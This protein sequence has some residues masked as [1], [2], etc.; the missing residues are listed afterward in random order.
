M[1]AV[2]SPDNNIDAE[3]ADGV[4][5]ADLAISSIEKAQDAS[6]PPSVD[7]EEKTEDPSNGNVTSD[8]TSNG[9]A[10]QW[11]PLATVDSALLS[12]LLDPRERRALLR[13]ERVLAEFTDS[14]LNSIEVGGAFNTIVLGENE[15]VDRGYKLE[16]CM[17]PQNVQEF[18]FQ[19]S[20]GLRQTS[21]QRL[22]LH[23]LADRFGIVREVIPQNEN[24]VTSL[25]LIRLI[26]TEESCVPERMVAEV[27]PSVLVGWRNPLARDSR[28]NNN[29]GYNN[30]GGCGN[31]NA[32]G[33]TA[34]WSPNGEQDNMH[35]L[36][37]HMANSSLNN[38][39]A[40]Q[41]T[42]KMV[43]MKRSST[44]GSNNDGGKGKKEGKSRNRKKLVDKEKAYEEA[45]ARI[46]GV[47]KG[48]DDVGVDGANEGA[49]YNAENTEE[50]EK[51]TV[52]GASG[53]SSPD[54][55]TE[56]KQL[57]PQVT[58]FKP[59]TSLEA[60]HHSVDSMGS[61]SESVELGDRSKGEKNESNAS[62]QEKTEVGQRSNAKQNKKSSKGK[63][64]K[65]SP[66][67]NNNSRAT[68]KAVYRNR[69]Q[70]EADPDFKR[71]AGPTYYTPQYAQNPYAQNVVYNNMVNVAMGQHPNAMGGQHPNLAMQGH[72][73]QHYYGQQQFYQNH[74]TTPQSPYF[75][76]GYHAQHP[77]DLAKQN[78]SES[79]PAALN[80]NFAAPDSSKLKKD[81]IVTSDETEQAKHQAPQQQDQVGTGGG[82][83]PKVVALKPDDFPALR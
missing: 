5:S 54:S 44:G 48:D 70:E 16:E 67:T 81:S 30:S 49:A 47:E 11:D 50:D 12:A 80:K 8:R 73:G 34:L 31:N 3:A 13:L 63:S 79:S 58:E 72:P 35:H 40:P 4:F 56:K 17:N 57:N 24:I 75:G 74:L 15:G 71:R 28:S 23:R 38:P 2:L 83:G 33:Y 77:Q 39:Q 21:F 20:R 7:K 41:P 29:M 62:P 53:D 18:Q 46:F 32:G 61:G 45:R 9:E 60:S 64:G 22:I 65:T 6:A 36:S 37:D 26:K 66:S 52:Q 51:G 10:P 59:H 55:K 42:K 27:D 76:Q 14:A 78:K 19:Q 68:G 1:A 43:I 82:C 69:Q 25:N